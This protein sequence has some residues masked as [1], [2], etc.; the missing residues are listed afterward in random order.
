M[1]H[2]MTFERVSAHG[3]HSGQFC[4]HAQDRLEEVV[5]AYVDQGY[6][7]IGLTEHM[8]P[9]DDRF[10]YPEERAAGLDSA[11]MARRF[12]RYMAEARRLQSAYADRM[13]ILVAF[14]TEATSGALNLALRLIDRYGPDYVV[15]SVHHVADIS[16]DYSVDAYRQ[17][18]ARCGGIESLY[19]HYFDRQ[20]D[21]L[22]RLRPAV[23]GHFDLIRLFDPSYERH[24]ALPDVQARITR[25][26]TLIKD[27]GML[28]DYNVAALRKGAVEP[29]PSRAILDQARAMGIA[30]VPGD[31]A[32]GV[33]MVGLYLDEGMRRLREAGWDGR[34]PK[35]DRNQ[36]R[37]H[38]PN[39]PTDVADA[40]VR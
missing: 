26:L 1:V 18:V 29:Y 37:A 35:P 17:A 15:G 27:G 11:A 21:L 23:V 3:G 39:G 14:E 20:Y 22:R 13:E 28:L 36:D 25:N 5:Q 19:C 30:L 34:W 16:F 8:P 31:D 7:W 40:V 4:C 38:R 24:L 33:A 6:A 32:H 10:L 12:D 2:H 9:V